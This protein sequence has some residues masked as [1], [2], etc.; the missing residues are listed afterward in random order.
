MCIRDSLQADLIGIGLDNTNAR[1]AGRHDSHHAIRIGGRARA[2]Y[3]GLADRCEL[4][5]AAQATRS[6]AAMIGKVRRIEHT[7]HNEE[8]A[9]VA[10]NGMGRIELIGRAVQGMSHLHAGVHTGENMGQWP[11]R[12]RCV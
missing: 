4:G 10:G 6:R 9:R 3:C 11:G 12:G 1:A 8:S 5:V 2:Q 7:I